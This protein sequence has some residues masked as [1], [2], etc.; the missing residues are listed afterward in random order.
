[1]GGVGV[2][3]LVRV[4][5]DGRGGCVTGAFRLAF[6]PP[7][8]GTYVRMAH[9][10]YLREKARS[11]R[12]ERQL[13]ID[14]LAERLAL[15]RST[16]Y[17]WVRDLPIPGSGSGG[18]GRR[19][20]S[21]KVP[22]NAAEVQAAARSG[23]CRGCGSTRRSR[24]ADVSGLR[25]PLH[26]GG[27]QAGSEHRLDLQLGSRGHKMARAGSAACREKAPKSGSSTTPTRIWMSCAS[28]G[29]AALGVD[30]GGSGRSASRTATSWRA[31]WRSRHGF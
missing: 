4:S 18:G 25:V 17:Y 21:A 30:P 31:L 9:A 8:M 22:C 11:M 23:I 3:G 14:E 16:I 29:A 7:R 28:S 5:W 2:V 6:R 20:R 1:M 15:S 26:R 13:T 10:A 24:G 12:V 19:G 27:V